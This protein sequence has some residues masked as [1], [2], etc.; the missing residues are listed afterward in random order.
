MSKELHMMIGG[1]GTGKSTLSKKMN[2]ELGYTIFSPD[3]IEN[4]NSHLESNAIDELIDEELIKLIS[5]GE[6]FI[7]DGK[8]LTVAGRKIIISRAK[9][10]GYT[11][12]GYDFGCGNI[13]T[14]LRR[15]NE[16]RDLFRD[17]WEGVYQ[18]DRRNYVEPEI[19]EGFER[20]YMPDR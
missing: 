12:Y 15:L 18:S 20:I 2:I 5:S 10:N 9:E 17:L 4:E 1:T 7:L 8:C 14:L 16:P 11:I 6:S 19:E 13:V 3:D